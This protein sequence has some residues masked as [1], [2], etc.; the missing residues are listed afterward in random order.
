VS[1]ELVRY[2]ATGLPAQ[3]RA[4]L[5]E[6]IKTMFVQAP[7]DAQTIAVL[8]CQRYGLDPLAKHLILIPSRGKWTAYITRD[9]MEAVAHKSRVGWSVSYRRPERRMN[10]YSSQEDIWLEGTL[11]RTG[12]PANSLGLWLSEC[13]TTSGDGKLNDLWAKRPGMGH[14]KAVEL[15]LLRRSFSIAVPLA[16]LTDIGDEP[17]TS[18][19]NGVIDEDT[20]EV[21]DGEVSEVKAPPSRDGGTHASDPANWE[22]K[23]PTATKA[24]GKPLTPEKLRE[25]IGAKI[26]TYINAGKDG[27]ITTD[28]AQ[29]V[30]STLR[31]H[32]VSD[33]GRH[34]LL[35]FLTGKTSTKDLAQAEAL[36]ILDWL[37]AARGSTAEEIDAVMMASAQAAENESPV[38]ESDAVTEAGG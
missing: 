9:G 38:D 30:A 20:G 34:T 16:P 27:P 29:A 37:K 4:E 24:N 14:Q 12:Y 17:E 13:Q 33:Q 19:T 21:I 10:P 11:Y 25:F 22:P 31:K 6:T 28:I 5:A 3:T 32:N 15:H 23:P 7:P 26:T 2:E 35:G 1:E 8:L 18:D 36:A